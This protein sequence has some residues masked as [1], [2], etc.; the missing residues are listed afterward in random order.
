MTGRALYRLIAGQKLGPYP[1]EQLRPL[2]K[3][4]RISRLDRF[5]Y[6]GVDWQG[7]DRFPELITPPTEDQPKKLSAI[8]FSLAP[9]IND[10]VPVA[11]KGYSYEPQVLPKQGGLTSSLMRLRQLRFR[12][13]FGIVS[14]T[15][16]GITVLASC[17]IL[18][19]R[20]VGP[21]DIT[22]SF[23][24]FVKSP[25]SYSGKQLL[26]RGI[27]YPQDLEPRQTDKD[28]TIKF[29]STGSKKILISGD[30]NAG[31]MFVVPA[32]M[33]NKLMQIVGRLESDQHVMLEFVCSTEEAAGGPMCVGYVSQITFFQD[34][35]HSEKTPAFLAIDKIGEL[36]EKD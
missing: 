34:L 27:Y 28:F 14:A 26:V 8:P 19:Q 3:D 33:G 4:G 30:R 21:R 20:N 31:L 2:V 23:S 36:Q 5:S 25:A 16:V 29:R 32:A 1:L 12:I 11:N 24:E 7:A 6:D 35:P 15:V 17:F 10:S 13:V 18:Y 9:A 22:E